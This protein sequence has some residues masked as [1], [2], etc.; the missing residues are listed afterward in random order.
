MPGVEIGNR[1]CDLT[2]RRCSRANRCGYWHDWKRHL[3]MRMDTRPGGQNTQTLHPIRSISQIQ[4]SFYVRTLSS[5]RHK[6]HLDLCYALT[7]FEWWKSCV[8]LIAT[9]HTKTLSS[10]KLWRNVH[11]PL[12]SFNDTYHFSQGRKAAKLPKFKWELIWCSKM[13][14]MLATA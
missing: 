10:E 5:S 13:K 9:R 1:N 7:T 14:S 4:I 3:V 2:C 8:L 11:L 12:P 6:S